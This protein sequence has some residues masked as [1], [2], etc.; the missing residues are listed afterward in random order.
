MRL[1]VLLLLLTSGCL[2]TD[3]ASSGDVEELNATVEDAAD[4]IDDLRREI[5]D[6]NDALC[7]LGGGEDC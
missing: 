1:V 3:A 6:P 7:E 4:E 5:A 2:K